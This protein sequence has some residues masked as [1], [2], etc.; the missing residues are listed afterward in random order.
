MIDSFRDEYFF[1]SNFYKT[2]IKYGLLVYP[3]VEHAFQ[4]QKTNNQNLRITISKMSSPAEAKR[5]G[6]VL[7]L[8]PDWIR[9]RL[10]IMENL[11]RIKFSDDTL[12]QML[13]HTRPHILVEGNTW[14]DTF[15]GVCRGKGENH[16][17]KLLMQIRAEG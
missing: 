15:W 16:L 1:L 4:A 2:P 10:N 6:R 7:E 9:V 5:K 13:Q 14:G 11:L 3:S 17:G 12:S 8:R